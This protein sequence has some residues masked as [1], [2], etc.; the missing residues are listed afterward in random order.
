MSWT[1][2]EIVEQLVKV[3][4]PSRVK[5]DHDDLQFY[6]NDWSNIEKPNPSA[7]VFPKSIKEVQAIVDLANKLN[8]PLV[9][10]GGRT[11]LSGGAL[12]K[13]RELVVSFDRMNLIL[14]FNK[15]DNLVT[16][17]PGVVTG[18]LKD[19]AESKGLFYPVDF[20]SV[21]SSQV[22]GNV[23]TNAGGVNVIRYGMTRDWIK[24]IK[25]V[26]GTGELLDLNRG[27]KKNATGFDF[28]H[29]FIG[30]EGTLGFIVELTLEFTNPPKDLN[31]MLMGLKSIQSTTQ[32]LTTFRE[33]LDLTA[34]EFFSGMAMQKVLESKKLRNPF[35]HIYPFYALVEFEDYY[36][37]QLSAA[38][39]LFEKCI[40]SGYAVE[41]LLSQN[42]RQA[43]QFW[44][45][46]EGITESIASYKPFK[47]DVSCRISQTPA[48]LDGLDKLL[49]RFEPKIEAVL[50]GHLGDG[51][52][53]INLLKP[54]QMDSEEFR[55]ECKTIVERIFKLVKSFGGSISAEH[56]IGLTKKPYLN[57]SRDEAELKYM[58]GVKRLFDPK[59]IMNPGKLIDV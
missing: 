5:V 43:R 55:E 44:E 35:D 37:G 39:E 40:D 3:V 13:D 56:G 34:F 25:V 29:L 32:V 38:S 10:S 14:E 57:Y 58:R 21:G 7:I 22:G 1:T 47:S 24:G 45:F 54:T 19:F 42:K 46:R 48:F 16:C 11:G 20:A 50:F 33:T 36:D 51:N 49:K 53:H 30:S 8:F 4:E 41:G 12:A 2:K 15:A 17:Q 6:G 52:V 9:P 31:V 23:A 59:N 26:T 28:R 27:L 18:V